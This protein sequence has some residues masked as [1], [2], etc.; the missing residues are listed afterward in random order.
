MH[1]S[2]K[3][4]QVRPVNVSIG[5]EQVKSVTDSTAKSVVPENM[6]DIFLK[7]PHFC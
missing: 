7:K 5:L 4:E 2:V 3:F 6:C 1:T